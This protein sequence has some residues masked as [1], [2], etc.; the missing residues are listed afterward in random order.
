MNE[1]YESVCVCVPVCVRCHLSIPFTCFIPFPAA[2]VSRT[3][4]LSLLVAFFFFF[5]FFLCPVLHTSRFYL[6]S[7]FFFFL[8]F[9]GD[10][11]VA[12]LMHSHVIFFLL[13]SAVVFLNFLLICHHSTVSHLIDAHVCACILLK[14]KKS[15]CMCVFV[16]YKIH[17]SDPSLLPVAVS[18]AVVVYLVKNSD[19]RA[20]YS[21]QHLSAHLH[22]RLYI[23][24]AVI[25][26]II[27]SIKNKRINNGNK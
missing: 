21:L 19:T 12:R 16:C 1:G 11:V 25:S 27:D 22:T 7:S 8:A 14:K 3:R 20:T 5:L 6:L 2:S 4:L 26:G 15:Y 13:S 18:G 17:C 9:R 23:R 24:K 10:F